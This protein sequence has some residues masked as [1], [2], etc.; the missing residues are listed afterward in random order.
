MSFAVVEAWDRNI[1][2]I[3]GDGE[4]PLLRKKARTS[5]AP[6]LDGKYEI[7]VLYVGLRYTA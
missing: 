5:V 1:R 6:D 4:M 2:L 3:D 7:G